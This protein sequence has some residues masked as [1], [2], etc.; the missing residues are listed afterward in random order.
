MSTS[1]RFDP[2]APDRSAAASE[3][4][5]QTSSQ[6]HAA[7]APEGIDLLGIIRQATTLSR[8]YQTKTIERPLARAYRA[9]QNQHAEGSKY[10]GPAWKGR[11]R[12]FMPKTRAAVRKNLATAAG[13]L[14]STE[15]VVSIAATFE[16]D[17]QQMATASVIKADLD[18]RLTQ[19]ASKFGLPWFLT[20]MG[21]NLDAQL[22]GVCISKQFW[23]FEEVATGQYHQKQIP[24]LHP[25][26][27][28]PMLDVIRD[29]M[30]SPVVDPISQLPTVIPV[31]EEVDDLDA[32]IMRI[33]KDRP[34]VEIHP[35]ENAGIDPAASWVDPAQRG[36][37]FFMRYAMGLS[38]VRA[39]LDSPGKGGRDTAWLA[40]V[41]TE[42]LT[43]GRIED[44]RGARRAR[45]GS[46]SNRYED[47]RGSNDLDIVWIQE[48][49]VRVAGR[50][51][52][53][54]SVGHWGYLSRVRETHEA[55]PEFEGE[56]PYKMGV[57][58]IDTHRVFPMSPVE[59]W[60]PLQLELNDITNLRQ[61]TL[62][63][64]IAPLAMV[65]RGKNV[66]LAQMQRRGQPEAVLLLDD[67]AQDVVFQPT[68]G[69]TG[70]AYTETSQV[71]ASFDELAGV[72]STSSV[73]T[74][75][76]LNETVG[77]MRLMAG[78][79]NSVSEFDLRVWIE[80]WVEPVLRQLVHLIRFNESDE[81]ILAIAGQKARV[82]QRYQYMPNLGDFEQCELTLR[83]N[84]GIGS[85]DP[86][87][88]LAKLKMA[89]EMLA[90]AYE[91][92]KSQGVTLNAEAIVT[93]VFG[94]AGFRDGGRFFNFGDPPEQEQDP[95]AM[96]ELRKIESQEKIARENNETKLKVEALEAKSQMI[97]TIVEK[98]AE[99]EARKAGIDAEIAAD[100]RAQGHERRMKTADMLKERA[101]REQDAHLSS[102]DAER[103]GAQRLKEIEASTRAKVAGASNGRGTQAGGGGEDRYSEIMTRLDSQNEALQAIVAHLM[104]GGQRSGL[105]DMG[106]PYPR[107]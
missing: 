76:Q 37:W 100:E 102:Q 81:K 99:R 64:A 52:H 17:A 54:W 9:W 86:M 91:D 101:A 28:E 72:F 92:M 14:F 12:L 46:G 98:L 45:E 93:E 105:P 42:L 32:P 40:D 31:M 96:I 63:R 106:V 49:F 73:Q 41:P 11:S 1:S 22:T 27:Q 78:S 74:S 62:K 34:V 51:Y 87:Q 25:D 19:A 39:M 75:R 21:A 35:V 88:K 84:A 50:D 44:D 90:P 69:P 47:G 13:A 107:A 104:Q 80:T 61:D 23:E 55:Y 36:R 30:G 65:K 24:A 57:A 67:P 4:A 43:K 5:G 77:G 70:A 97:L 66:D 33:I 94:Q 20:A 38:D 53:F 58:A 95:K 18:H 26:T 10:L 103:S 89:F 68:P 83:V 3:S 2:Q 85:A 56:R 29:E 48:N 59:S 16:D 71:N 8:E 82:W 6:A 7:G 60:Q 79:S 15:D